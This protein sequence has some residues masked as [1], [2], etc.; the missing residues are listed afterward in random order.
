[1]IRIV[2]FLIAFIVFAIVAVTVTA[3][4]QERIF[5]S[6]FIGLPAG[7]IAGVITFIYLRVKDRDQ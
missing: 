4:L 6:V 2:H 1:M 7:T 5:F 3:L